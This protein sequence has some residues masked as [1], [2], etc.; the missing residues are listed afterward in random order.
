MI[1]KVSADYMSTIDPEILEQWRRLRVILEEP[2]IIHGDTDTQVDRGMI[3]IAG[4]LPQLF[5]GRHSLHILNFKWSVVNNVSHVLEDLRWATVNLPLAHFCYLANDEDELFALSEAGADVFM[6]NHGIFL[7]EKVFR[8]LPEGFAPAKYD[9]VYDARF[10]PFKNHYLCS[11]I[12]KLALIYYFYPG[13]PNNEE[14]VRQILPNA[15]YINHEHGKGHYKKLSAEEINIILNQSSAGLCL[16]HEEGA[17]LA[18]LQYLLAG[19]PVVTI[20][21]RGGRDRFFLPPY[22]QIVA[23]DAMNITSSVESFKSLKLSRAAVREYAATL[24]SFERRNFLE[25]VNLRIRK[26]FG[27][28][29][30]LTDF[31]IFIYDNNRPYQPLEESLKPLL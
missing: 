23:A 14:E 17:M 6:G 8:P 10:S 15:H 16:S 26:I 27:F 20:P 11:E 18:S 21:S 30:D 29:D 1:S 5:Q 28:T 25:A 9:A 31:S 22:A 12:Q 7:D 3:G 19:T 4:I 13:M 24:V 2:L